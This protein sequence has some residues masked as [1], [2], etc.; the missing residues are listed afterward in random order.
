MH[1]VAVH[2][3]D[4]VFQVLGA[5]EIGMLFPEFMA[6]QAALGRLFTGQRPKPDDLGRIS[7]LGMFLARTMAR[8]AS[9]PLGS[10]VLGQ[11]S[12]PVRP[13]LEALALLFVAGLAGI[14][15]YVLGR[16]RFVV[17]GLLRRDVVTLL[18]LLLVAALVL[19]IGALAACSL[20]L[21]HTK[22][23]QRQYHD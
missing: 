10:L 19:L 15:S 4:I 18:V 12:F 23:N 3:A 13:P 5:Q 22:A 17:I 2:A 16:I 11:I 20:A 8:F 21:L 9:L 1:G 6:S 14:R 7:R